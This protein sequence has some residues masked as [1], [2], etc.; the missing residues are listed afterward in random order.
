[1]YLR[2]LFFLCRATAAICS[3]HMAQH[4]AESREG[5]DLIAGSLPSLEYSPRLPSLA[6]ANTTDYPYLKMSLFHPR[7]S[8]QVE[9][10][11]QESTSKV[12]E[13]PK[14]LVLAKN[15]KLTALLAT[16]T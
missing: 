12:I 9:D 4:L 15:S 5:I 8:R 10:A 7:K 1:M 14:C 2:V 13:P 11:L 6:E 16:G 3:S